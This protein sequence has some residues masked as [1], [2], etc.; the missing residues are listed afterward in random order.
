MFTEPC[1]SLVLNLCCIEKSPFLF[2]SIYI[3]IY[4]YIKF[5][6]INILKNI[7]ILIYFT[8]IYNKYLINILDIYKNMYRNVLEINIY[9]FIFIIRI[10]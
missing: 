9:L 2:V 7:Q 6:K 3:Y 4:V 1:S 5:L 8:Q 10:L